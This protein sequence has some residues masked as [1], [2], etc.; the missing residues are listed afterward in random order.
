M[1]PK[2]KKKKKKKE[3]LETWPPLK[4]KNSRMISVC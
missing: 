2:E 3:A 4:E 1:K